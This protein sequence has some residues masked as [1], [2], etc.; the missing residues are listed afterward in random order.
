MT[1]LSKEFIADSYKIYLPYLPVLRDAVH[2]GFCPEVRPILATEEFSGDSVGTTT[3]WRSRLGDDDATARA[4]VQCTGAPSRLWTF[5]EAGNITALFLGS[6][7]RTLSDSCSS[8]L[9]AYCDSE[10]GAKT[11]ITSV[12]KTP[13]Y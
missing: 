4:L 13:Q 5:C 10:P 3:L 1:T 9:T 6:H 8:L 12:R 2:I 11:T 7:G